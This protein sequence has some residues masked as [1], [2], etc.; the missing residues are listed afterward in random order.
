MLPAF[1]FGLGG[2]LGS[3]RPFM[4]WIAL[5]DVLGI[6]HRAL[7]DSC[8]EGPV[9]AVAPHPVRNAEFSRILADVLGRPTWL[10]VPSPAIRSLLGEMGQTLLLEGTRVHPGRLLERGHPF[11]FPE[12]EAALRHLLGRPDTP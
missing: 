7:F 4:S 1:R 8:L 12:L 9:N 6:L 10:T 2:K 3:G 11:R 5:D